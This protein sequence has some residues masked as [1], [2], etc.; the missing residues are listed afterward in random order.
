M[1]LKKNITLDN[2]VVLQY[3]RIIS[4][5]KIT[6]EIN[7]I[8][9]GSYVSQNTREEEPEKEVCVRRKSYDTDYSEQYSI[10]DA[11]DYLKTLEEYED[12]EDC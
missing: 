7:V 4:L 8:E 3:H 10:S 5:H 11:Y 2:G 1:A 9:V 6:N 12:A